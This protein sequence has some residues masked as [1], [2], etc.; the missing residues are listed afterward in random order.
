MSHQAGLAAASQAMKAGCISVDETLI[1]F[2]GKGDGLWRTTS[3][4]ACSGVAGLHG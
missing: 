4:V 2:P 3:F 1:R